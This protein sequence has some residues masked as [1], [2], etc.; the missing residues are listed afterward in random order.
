[1]GQLALAVEYLGAAIEDQLVLT[2]YLIE[3]DQRQT[4]LGTAL[5]HQLMANPGLFPIVGGGVDGQQ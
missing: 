1:M 4:C 5:R 3:V 2:A